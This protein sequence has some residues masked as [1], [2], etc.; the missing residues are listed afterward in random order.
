MIS[1]S[2]LLSKS[3]LFVQ[4]YS[5]RRASIQTLSAKDT[6]NISDHVLGLRARK[7][8]LQPENPI[9][10]MKKK[11]WTH[12][13]DKYSGIFDKFDDLD[14]I[15]HTSANFDELLIPPDHV[16]RGL[17]DTYYVDDNHVLRTHTSAH[18]NELLRKGSRA[19]LAVGDCYRRD[20]VDRTHFPVFHQ[21]EGVRLFPM[22]STS[23]KECED[24]LKHVLASLVEHLFPGCEYR[25]AVDYFPF[26]DP[27]F[28]ME[29]KFND[30]WLEI[31]GCGVM[32]QKIIDNCGLADHRGWAFGLGLER[33]AMLLFEI[34]DIRLF[35][36]KDERF[37][38][39]FRGGKVKKFQPFSKYPSCYKDIAFWVP[40][41]FEENDLM[42]VIRSHGQDIV[43]EVSLI[44]EFEHPKHKRLSKCYRILYRA[45]DRTLTNEEIDEIQMRIRDELVDNLKIEVRG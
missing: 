23:A 3:L 17:T 41:G 1:Q 6:V 33:L 38:S 31:F 43:E 10:L 39:Q 40:S 28:E 35:W 29:V 27:S 9:C 36:S 24:D 22:E 30:D 20:T 26:T 2:A 15:V 12:F 19:F 14:E 13:D 25:W 16:S 37:L 42:D 7:L 8:H 34:N 18:Q 11:I 5:I 21:M 4:K 32:Q 44:D 45:T